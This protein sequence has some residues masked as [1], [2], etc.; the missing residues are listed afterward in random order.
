MQRDGAR[1]LINHPSVTPSGFT[2]TAAELA[3]LAVVDA[4]IE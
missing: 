2:G 3:A 1:P 4:K